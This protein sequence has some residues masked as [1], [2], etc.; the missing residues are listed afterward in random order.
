MKI[1]A[2]GDFHAKFPEKLNHGK[3]E[4]RNLKIAGF[5]GYLDPD[6]YFTK[7]GMRAINSDDEDIERRNNL[8]KKELKSG[9]LYYNCMQKDILCEKR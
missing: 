4:F 5:G 3:S 2:I 9:E 7:S 1:L 8:R 6:V